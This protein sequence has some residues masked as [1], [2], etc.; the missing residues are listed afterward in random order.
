[1]TLQKRGFIGD[2]KTLGTAILLVFAGGSIELYT[3]GV[4]GRMTFC[5]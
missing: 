3:L 1:M 5:Q 4:E 2:R